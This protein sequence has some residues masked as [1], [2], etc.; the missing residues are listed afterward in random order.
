MERMY[1][2]AFV[3]GNKNPKHVQLL[4]TLS[5]RVIKKTV[6]ASAKRLLTKW[7]NKPKND[8]YYQCILVDLVRWRTCGQ[9]STISDIFDET[10]SL[11]WLFRCHQLVREFMFEHATPEKQKFFWEVEFQKLVGCK[12]LRKNAHYCVSPKEQSQFAKTIAITRK[13]QY[14]GTL[15]D[16]VL[17]RRNFC[18]HCHN[19]I[20]EIYVP[21]SLPLNRRKFSRTTVDRYLMSKSLV[22]IIDST[23][24]NIRAFRDAYQKYPKYTTLLN[25][26][27]VG[28][29]MIVNRDNAY[30]CKS[31]PPEHSDDSYDFKKIYHDFAKHHPMWKDRPSVYNYCFGDWVAYEPEIIKFMQDNGMRFENGDFTFIISVDAPQ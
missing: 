30:F 19:V 20:Y 2:N 15:Q 31:K 6:R 23:L 7:E 11:D 21:T 27:G 18:Q 16:F 8:F 22:D 14:R 5:A 1:C 9:Y 28:G 25:S 4:Q 3:Y 24:E 17:D 26:N 12:F 13:N 10:K 29:Y